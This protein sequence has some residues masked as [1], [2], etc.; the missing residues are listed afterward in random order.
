MTAVEEVV[1][2]SIVVATNRPVKVLKEILTSIF[3]TSPLTTEVIV[4]NDDPKRKIS[5]KLY[6]SS[7]RRI[8]K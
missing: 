6:L 7:Q 2:L 3:E 5:E 1:E 8:S 4:I